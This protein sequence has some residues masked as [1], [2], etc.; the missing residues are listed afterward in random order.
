MAGIM[1]LEGIL[2]GKGT[3]DKKEKKFE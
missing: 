3:R 2:V 1:I